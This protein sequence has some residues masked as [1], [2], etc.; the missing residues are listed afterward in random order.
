MSR[1][2]KQQRTLSTPERGISSSS[3][4]PEHSPYARMSRD[5]DANTVLSFI[6]NMFS[7][8]TKN[9]TSQADVAKVAIHYPYT[10]LYIF[11]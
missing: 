1:A 11:I 7:L 3:L 6:G 4:T 9:L 2:L 5:M 8:S 10:P